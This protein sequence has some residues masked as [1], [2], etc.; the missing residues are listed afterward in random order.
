MRLLV[1]SCAGNCCLTLFSCLCS[2]AHFSIVV[3]AFSNSKDQKES[4]GSAPAKGPSKPKSLV[5]ETKYITIVHDE[6]FKLLERDEYPDQSR[7][8][9]YVNAGPGEWPL[10][11]LGYD[12]P[13]SYKVVLPSLLNLFTIVLHHDGVSIVT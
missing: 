2:Y 7:E 12:T 13:E 1:F 8:V 9:V 11:H 5:D 3:S 6:W 10:K 4:K